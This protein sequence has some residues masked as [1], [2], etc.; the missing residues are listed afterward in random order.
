M[1]MDMDDIDLTSLG[2]RVDLESF[3]D[4]GLDDTSNSTSLSNSLDD[5]AESSLPLDEEL[6]P[7]ED[8]NFDTFFDEQ[9]D[10]WREQ[11]VE[12]GDI[13][14]NEGTQESL[15][16]S[17]GQPSYAT[18]RTTTGQTIQAMDNETWSEGERFK[19][20][21]QKEGATFTETIEV[22]DDAEVDMR[23]RQLDYLREALP[24][25]PDNRL[26][27]IQKTFNKSLGDPSLLELTSIVR[28]RMPDYITSTWLKQMGSLTARYVMHAASQDGLV[29]VHM[30]NGVLE[31]DTSSGS[32]DRALEF[33][34]TQFTSQGLTPNGYSDRLVLQMF[35]K[36]NRL[37]R[38]LAFKL[39]VEEAG[40]TL[41]LQSYGSLIDFCGRHNQLGS[42]LLLLKE[43]LS[44]HKAAP[45]EACLSQIRVLCRQADLMEKV[46][47]TDLIGQDPAE[48]LR[49]GEANLKREYSKKG[50]RDV[51]ISRNALLQL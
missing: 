9:K 29:D 24:A 10:E 21:A 2:G 8:E 27:K 39:S 43:C 18:E 37:Q 48:W 14:A 36:N 17:T 20:L 28:E 13:E 22:L 31:L 25:F 44:V 19:G 16:A 38:A 5:N 42:G 4:F 41:D 46:G 26:V 6:E 32:L 51:Q 7:D 23:E 49:H 30:L 45:G 1:A 33:H 11:G 40:R 3:K 34:Q 35:V 47:L 12:L 50:R 15:S